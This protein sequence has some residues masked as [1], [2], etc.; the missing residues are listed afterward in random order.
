LYFPFFESVNIGKIS[1]GTRDDATKPKKIQFFIN[2][3]E[4]SFDDLKDVKPREE[5]NDNVNNIV[6]EN[7][8]EKIED[9]NVCVFNFNFSRF[10]WL[11][12]KALC[13]NQWKYLEM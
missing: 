13:W 4:L 10:C 3:G 1:F 6:L 8:T 5:F 2:E 7:K 12:M 11:E 9:L